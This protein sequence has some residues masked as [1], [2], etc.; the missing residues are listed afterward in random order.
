MR[1]EVQASTPYGLLSSEEVGATP[2]KASLSNVRMTSDNPADG[3]A[4]TGNTATLAFTAGRALGGLLGLPGATVTATTDGSGVRFDKTAH[5]GS[6]SINEGAA[7][8]VKIRLVPILKEEERK[9]VESQAATDT[10][11]LEAAGGC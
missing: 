10:V 7:E 9:E 5:A 2:G 4:R 3:W 6:F 11:T 1:R 8:D